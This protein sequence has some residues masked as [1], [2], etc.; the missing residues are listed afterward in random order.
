VHLVYWDLDEATLREAERLDGV[1]VLL[2]NLPAA[3]ADR[4][5][6]LRIWKGQGESERRFSDWK[7]PLKV[8]PV[9][10]TTP[11]RIS[12][13]L[14]LLHFALMIHSLLE[15]EGRRGA[16]R[17][18]MNTVVGLYAG[19]KDAIPTGRL[20]IQTFEFLHM[21]EYRVGG[22]LYRQLEPLSPLQERLSK[23]LGLTWPPW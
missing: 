14:V 4:H 9:F 18:G 5:E 13:L 11:R 6:L 1:T 7:G 20:I 17:L 15:R 21:V 3:E 2:T 8:R 19:H 10:L 12:A 16:K 23:M 22:K